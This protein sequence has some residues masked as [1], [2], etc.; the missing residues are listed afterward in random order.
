[1]ITT[2]E[3]LILNHTSL[4]KSGKKLFTEAQIR[5]AYDLGISTLTDEVNKL[6]EERDRLKEGLL[7]MKDIK[8]WDDITYVAH[9]MI[10]IIDNTL[11]PA[12]P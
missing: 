7:K 6:T 2:I 9:Q 5:M 12:K 11:N 3:Q 4:D 8:G 1:M 10:T